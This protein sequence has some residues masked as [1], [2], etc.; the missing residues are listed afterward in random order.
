MNFLMIDACPRPRGVSRSYRL[1]A[2]FRD[3]FMRLNP[4][5][6]LAELRLD[7]RALVPLTGAAERARSR[8]TDAAAFDDAS[9]ALA[10]QFAEADVVAICAP[11]WNF[12]FPAALAAYFEH[13][14]VSGVT[15]T[16]VDDQP[17]GLCRARALAYFTSAGGFIGADDWGYGYIRA[18]AGKL[19]GVPQFYCA[20]AD[21][22]DTLGA[23]VGA[24][25]TRAQVR[26]RDIA[27]EITRLFI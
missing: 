3:E 22:L 1:G 8:L 24:I 6:E 25:L 18:M 16:Y 14:C 2:A 4:C 27:A 12:Q 10:R 20:A 9:L 7:D 5:A 17:V 13:V 23:D 26:A 19:L 15:F 21:G 11:Y